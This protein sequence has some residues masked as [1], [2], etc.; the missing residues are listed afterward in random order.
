MPIAGV[1][2]TF[3]M[4][5]ELIQLVGRECVVAPDGGFQRVDHRI[6]GD[7]QPRGDILPQEVILVV[8]RRA[9]IEIRNG[10]NQLSVHRCV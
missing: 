10:G 8:H 7:E 3:V 1:I 9:E 4:C 5:Y 6:A 2:L